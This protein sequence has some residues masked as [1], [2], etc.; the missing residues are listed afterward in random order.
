MFTSIL[1]LFN[2]YTYFFGEREVLFVYVCARETIKAG[3]MGG[4][5]EAGAVGREG[6]KI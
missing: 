1:F 3:C 4:K 2:M 6:K 5:M